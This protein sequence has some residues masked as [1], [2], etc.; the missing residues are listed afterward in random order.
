MERLTKRK[1]DLKPLYNSYSALYT[2]L[3]EL[4]NQIEDNILVDCKNFYVYVGQDE[5]IYMKRNKVI[6]EYMT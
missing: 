4:E 2:R 5:H 3:R 1:I 6:P